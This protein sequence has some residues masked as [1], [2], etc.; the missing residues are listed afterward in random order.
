MVLVNYAMAGE[1]HPYTQFINIYTDTIKTARNLDCPK[2]VDSVRRM[3]ELQVE[4]EEK[5]TNLYRQSERIMERH[6]WKPE[7]VRFCLD[8]QD[9]NLTLMD[10]MSINRVQNCMMDL[11]SFHLAKN[12]QE[13]LGTEI[14]CQK[15]YNV[16]FSGATEKPNQNLE[17]TYIAARHR[18]HVV[19]T[20]FPQEKIDEFHQAL[21]AAS[22]H[23][24]LK[25]KKFLHD[26][27]P[28][29][30]A[31]D[32]SNDAKEFVVTTR[33]CS[34]YEDVP[35]TAEDILRGHHNLYELTK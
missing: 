6:I 27:E 7:S 32:K 2:I 18:C 30:Y 10:G 35:V 14:K 16:R 24:R 1:T 28:K 29:L 17:S 26:D 5:N 3:Q 34:S 15:P 20:D 12:A 11:G 31:M 33:R 23:A 22:V 9:F 8:N 25:L 21:D 4:I 13:I 19:G